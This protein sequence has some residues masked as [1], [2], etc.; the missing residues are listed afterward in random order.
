MESSN[1][2][3]R[4]S[5]PNRDIEKIPV[6]LISHISSPT[7]KI[8]RQVAKFVAKVRG[9]DEGSDDRKHLSRRGTSGA[10]RDV[11]QESPVHPGHHVRRPHPRRAPRTDPL[12]HPTV[13]KR[14]CKFT[15]DLQNECPFLKKVCTG[16]GN[17]DDR[18]KCSHCNSEFS[19]A[20]GDRSDINDHLQSSKHK[21]SLAC[22]A[23]SSKL[24]NCFKTA[25][26]NDTNLDLAAKEA[27]FAYHTANRSLSFNSNSCSSKLISKFFEPKFSL[28]KTKCEAIVLNVL[29][30][31]AQEELKEDLTK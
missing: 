15:E 10:Q 7:H 27:T 9:P 11:P 20:H 31:L 29:A 17:Q 8:S 26:S 2:F 23:S 5:S 19:V 28:G 12:P 18:A 21:K 25:S 14:S 22:A 4:I 30:P 13:P 24:T 16:T 1:T 6:P 3:K